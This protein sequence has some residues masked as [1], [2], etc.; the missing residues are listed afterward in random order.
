MTN[1]IWFQNKINATGCVQLL[2]DIYLLSAQPSETMLSPSAT[3]A[4]HLQ[5]LT[6]FLQKHFKSLNYDAQQI[7]SLLSTYLKQYSL[8]HSEIINNV[9]VK[10]WKEEVK[11]LNIMRIERIE[12]ESNEVDEDED[13]DCNKNGYDSLI[14]TNHDENFMISLSTDREEICVWNVLQ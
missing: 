3:L 12:T 9:I 8:E 10:K 14:N 1:L 5:F 13:E 2:L 11:E 4:E 7:F 6:T